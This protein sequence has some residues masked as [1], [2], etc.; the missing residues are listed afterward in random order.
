M[1]LTDTG[2]IKP[3]K[4]WQEPD[5]HSVTPTPYPMQCGTTAALERHGSSWVCSVER[6]HGSNCSEVR[7]GE[8]HGT[9]DSLLSAILHQQRANS[10]PN[11]RQSKI[12]YAVT[13]KLSWSIVKA[14][15]P[16]LPVKSGSAH[17][18]ESC[19]VAG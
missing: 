6:T 17:P 3:N 7:V 13:A 11:T 5:T 8:Q 1:Q 4:H 10:L 2:F 14:K 15:P 16:L 19:I 18:A 12:H 9:G